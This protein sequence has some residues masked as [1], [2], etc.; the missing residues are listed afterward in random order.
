MEDTWRSTKQKVE[1]DLLS[2]IQVQ[3]FH[4][5]D[6]LAVSL[7]L[8]DNLLTPNAARE[9]VCNVHL[10]SLSMIVTDSV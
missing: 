4:A 10:S 5:L 2:M 3:L 6:S 1:W 7:H 8:R 9:Q